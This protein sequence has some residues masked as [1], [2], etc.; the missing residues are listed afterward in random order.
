[1]ASN[2]ILGDFVVQYD[3]ERELPIGDIQVFPYT[4]PATAVDIQRAWLQV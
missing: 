1:M 3:V 2:G 4:H